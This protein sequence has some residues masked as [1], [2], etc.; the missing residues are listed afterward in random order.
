MRSGSVP[1][2]FETTSSLQLPLFSS[3]VRAGFP[4]PADDH[5]EPDIDLN[6]L[7]V[8]NPVA[9]FL[10]RVDGE[11]MIDAG[12]YPEDLVVVDRSLTV[13][14]RDVV[15]AEVEGEFLIKRFLR[16]NGAI[17]LASENPVFRPLIFTPEM[18][19]SIFGVVTFTLHRHRTRRWR[20]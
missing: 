7:L 19:L 2:P 14:Q 15:V 10:L 12:I 18:D 17:L 3:Y 13:Q 16:Q 1:V 5:H 6:T 11:S 9:T 8:R 4:N 20:R